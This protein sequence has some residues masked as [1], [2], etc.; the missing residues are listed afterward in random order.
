MG[1]NSDLVWYASYGSNIFRQRFD[2]YIKGGRI[3]GNNRIYT[4]A[5]DT[6]PPLSAQNINIPYQLYFAKTSVKWNG[7]GVGFIRHERD[8]KNYTLGKM[9]LIT[10][11]QFNDVVRQESNLRQNIEIDFESLQRQGQQ[12]VINNV[13]YGRMPTWGIEI[14]TLFLALLI[15]LT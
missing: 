12:N 8:G 9:Y 1:K 5:R 15:A 2:C 4:G 6:T 11:Q 13:W 3:A 7:G 14:A 10:R